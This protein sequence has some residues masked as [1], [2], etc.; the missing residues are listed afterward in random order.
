L[1]NVA[2]AWS[3]IDS[4]LAGQDNGF[5][6][7]GFE[8]V[9]LVYRVALRGSF[10]ASLI[11]GART[12]T[13]FTVPDGRYHYN[14]LIRTVRQLTG[15]EQAFWFYVMYPDNSFSVV[16]WVQECSD[17]ALDE[18]LSRFEMQ[19]APEGGVSY[20]GLLG[21]NS[22]WLLLHK[23]DPDEE[24]GITFHGSA[25]MCEELSRVLA[26]RTQPNPEL[27][28]DGASPRR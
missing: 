6:P 14:E 10:L 20:L 1:E 4:A 24:F 9:V 21:G 19:P 7:R 28:S 8:S 2:A 16:S 27:Q 11:N 3:W 23:Y 22:R 12:S 13:S 5:V 25:K 17:E 18:P 15:H 26:V